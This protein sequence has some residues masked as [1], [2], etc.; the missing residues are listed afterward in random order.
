MAIIGFPENLRVY[1]DITLEPN[2]TSY[3]L[4]NRNT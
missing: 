2:N 3:H 4:K 1:V